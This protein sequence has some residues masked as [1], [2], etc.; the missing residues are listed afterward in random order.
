MRSKLLIACFLVFAG[1]AVVIAAEPGKK[2]DK[3]QG[4]PPPMLVAVAE[5]VQGSAEPMQE[6]VGTVYFSRVSKV[7]AEVDGLVS[8]VAVEDGDRVK[9]GAA[10]VSLQT[11]ILQT[12]ITK[13]RNA[14]EQAVIDME[15]GRKDLQRLESLHADNLIADTTYDAQSTR[16]QGLEKQAASL[17]AELDRL[18]LEKQKKIIRAPFSG[19][20][21]KREVEKGEWV[22]IGGVV[23]VVADDREVDIVVDIPERLIGFM[24]KGREVS[25]ASGN[26][27]YTGRYIALIPQGDI[28]TRTFS[29]KIRMKNKSGLIEGM[30]ARASL[31]SG[32][33]Q[34]GLLVPRDAVINQFGQQVV[35]L[36]VDGKAKLVPIQI[37]GYQGMQVAV[38]G[39]DLAA[40]QQVVVK[41][42]ERIRDGQAIRF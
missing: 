24:K 36:A 41:G 27:T 14:Y 8:A 34:D 22:N 17:Q 23:A 26:Q 28:A 10:L 5:I 30:A 33:K 13:T 7:A 35:L 3:K 2:T 11:D 40:G 38:T 37:N 16:S 31:P 21:L 15:Q 20:V 32:P 42:N 19:L 4:G 1:A 39:P 29:I 12:N 18:Q 6:L 25:I 9:A